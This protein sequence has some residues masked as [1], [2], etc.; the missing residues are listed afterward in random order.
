M[1]HVLDESGLFRDVE[2]RALKPGDVV[3][4]KANE[5]IPADLVLL[6]CS[7]PYGLCYLETEQ[8]GGLMSHLNAGS[9]VYDFYFF[10]HPSFA[11]MLFLVDGETNLKGKTCL[12]EFQEMF[13]TASSIA[14]AHCK[15]LYNKKMWYFC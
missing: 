7:D 14:S 5:Q 13:P 4:V 12:T 10:S 2:W 6:T 9:F 11:V 15:R 1:A 3:Y 8:L